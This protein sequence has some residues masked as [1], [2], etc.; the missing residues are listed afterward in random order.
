MGKVDY[1]PQF[2]MGVALVY[3]TFHIMKRVGFINTNL[4]LPHN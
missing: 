2:I 3:A 1:I 4:P